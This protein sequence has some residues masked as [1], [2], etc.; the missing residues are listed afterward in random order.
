M[1]TEKIIFW[2]SGNFLSL[3][4]ANSLQKKINSEL[5]LVAKKVKV[6]YFF[7]GGVG[8]VRAGRGKAKQGSGRFS[9][10]PAGLRARAGPVAHQS[11]PRLRV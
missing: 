11:V 1:V 9:S 10:G 6:K 3:F 4:L 8:S 5:A 2:E 7:H